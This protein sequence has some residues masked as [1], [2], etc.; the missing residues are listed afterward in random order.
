[1]VCLFLLI[2]Y[3][4]IFQDD[5]HTAESCIRAALPTFKATQAL[6][7]YCKTRVC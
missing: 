4:A 3:L 5:L 6:L 2:S 1:M 7:S